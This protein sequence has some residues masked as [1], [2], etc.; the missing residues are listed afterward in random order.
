MI[1]HCGLNCQSAAL[2]NQH[3]IVW[4]TVFAGVFYGTEPCLLA[5]ALALIMLSRHYPGLIR[6]LKGTEEKNAQYL[7]RKK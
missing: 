2:I 3:F 5:L 1:Y 4:F 6:S 7:K